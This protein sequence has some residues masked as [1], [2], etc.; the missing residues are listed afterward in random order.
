MAEKIG[1][2]GQS[3]VTFWAIS[4]LVAGGIAILSTWITAFIPAGIFGGL[5]ASRLEGG[6]LNQLRAQV[7]QLN[8]EQF[9]LLQATNRLRGQFSLSERKRADASQRLVA[10]E[11]SIPLLLEVVPPDAGIDTF[12]ITA[13][14]SDE[15]G[16]SFEAEGGSVTFTQAPLFD[17]LESAND[18]G[19]NLQ[20]AP[21]VLEST[22]ID[23][24]EVDS[25]SNLAPPP[26]NADLPEEIEQTD[27][28]SDVQTTT[29]PQ[30]AEQIQYG[31][32]VGHTVA[33]QDAD[34]LWADISGKVGALLIGL[35]PA[36][37]DP[38]QNG[39][40]RV[41]VGPVSNYL[42]ADMLCRRINR[43]G[44]ECLPIQYGEQQLQNL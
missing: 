29:D 18:D 8:F 20:P 1:Q 24:P 38:L 37:S 17:D 6:T 16:G 32:A 10:L 30:P 36:I 44:I 13:S 26:Q 42:E 22:P 5:H 12:A 40:F 25:E 27:I 41:V 28:I 15:N 21:D 4:A 43:I 33:Q 9:E 3:D 35:T 19:V 14:V 23:E 31:I 39:N 11:V 2:P 7:E 34:A